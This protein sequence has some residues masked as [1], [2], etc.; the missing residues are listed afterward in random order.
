MARKRS[1]CLSLEEGPTLVTAPRV[2]LGDQAG[3]VVPATAPIFLWPQGW[4]DNSRIGAPASAFREWT[5]EKNE[6]E[7]LP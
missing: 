4:V 5:Q 3:T 6:L 7:C 1:V 2:G